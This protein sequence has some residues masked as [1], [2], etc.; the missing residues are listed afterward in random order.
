MN[1]LQCLTIFHIGKKKKIYPLVSTYFSFA[2]I[3]ITFFF[4]HTGRNEDF[5]PAAM[6]HIHNDCCYIVPQ[7][8]FQTVQLQN[9][10]TP[11]DF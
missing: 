10:F 3:C 5:S 9:S 8:S 6:L 1:V 2:A 4:L 11:S 7:F